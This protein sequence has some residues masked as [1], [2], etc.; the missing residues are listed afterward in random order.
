MSEQSPGAESVQ[1][2]S[3]ALEGEREAEQSGFAQAAR[4]E[5]EE[6]A[7]ALAMDMA[8]DAG[9]QPTGSGDTAGAAGVSSQPGGADVAADSPGAGA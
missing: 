3:T 6:D 4:A 8:A 2:M 5:A 9:P 7:Q 1:D